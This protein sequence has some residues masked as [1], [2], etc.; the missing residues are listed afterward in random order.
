[1]EREQDGIKAGIEIGKK[2]GKAEAIMRLYANGIT[3]PYISR[4]LNV[5]VKDIEAIISNNKEKIDKII[6][7][8]KLENI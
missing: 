8:I 1:M 4:L 6:E 7:E 2:D 3:L 5:P